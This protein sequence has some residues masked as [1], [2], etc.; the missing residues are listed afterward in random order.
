MAPK[1]SADRSAVPLARRLADYAY[2]LRYDDLDPA[3]IERVKSHLVD[4]LGCGIAAVDEGPVRICR[5][6][7]LSSAGGP[8]TVIS[9]GRRTN[10]DLA[11]FANSAAFRYYDLNDVYVGR[12]AC[13]PSDNIA[14]CLAVAEARAH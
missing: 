10:A 3:T 13:H 5:D 6:L 12:A 4:T 11:A 9:T 7:A 14:A 8:S 2:R 1:Q